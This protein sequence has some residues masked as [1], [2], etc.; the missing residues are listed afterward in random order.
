MDLSL[1][2]FILSAVLITAFLSGIVG[3]AGDALLLVI[4][5]FAGLP[6]QQAAML[7]ATSLFFSCASRAFIHRKQLY[8]K[9]LEYFFVGL[10]FAL[11]I[12]GP[13]PGIAIEKGTQDLLRGIG[14]ALLGIAFFIPFLS[15]GKVKPDFTKQPHALLCAVMTAGF[16]SLDSRGFLLNLFFQDIPLTRYQVISTK[17]VAQLIPCL[18]LFVHS[19]SVISGAPDTPAAFTLVCL[20]V[21]IA[22]GLGSYFGKHA[23]AKMT[24]V[25]FYKVTQVILLI[26]GAVYLCGAFLLIRQ[27]LPVLQAT[28]KI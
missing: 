12:F 13:L 2:P 8:T 14:Q 4:L 17:A 3:M 24:D 10:L 26:M 20:A 5:S 28:Q 1:I 23:L 15:R 27:V 9:S 7:Y 25:Q 18:L 11:F 16:K 6:V 21:A 22:A 19:G